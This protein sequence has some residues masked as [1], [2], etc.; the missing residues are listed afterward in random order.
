MRLTGR[1]WGAIGIGVIAG[2]LAYP[3]GR[4]E[5]L[6]VAGAAILLPA[7]GWVVA[8]VRRPRFEV[9]RAFAPPVAAAGAP[10]LVTLR[11]RNAAA[12]ASTAL[13]WNDALPWDE[14]DAAPRAL[15]PIPAGGPAARVHVAGYELH[16]HRRGVYAIGPLVVENRDP[17]GMAASVAA[18]GQQDRLVVVPEIAELPSGGPA[19]ADGEGAA[20]LV[21]RRISGNDDDLTTREYR[22]GDALRRVHW[23]ASARHGELMVRQEEHRSHPDARI[24]VDT[25]LGGYPDAL[26]DTGETWDASSSSDS[27]E[28][29]VRMTAS[30]GMH[31]EANGFQVTVE[32][33][34]GAQIEPLGERWEGGRR[35]EGFLT[36]LAGVRLLERPESDL[37]ASVSETVGPVFAV[38]GDPEDATVEWLVRRRRGAELAIVFAVQARPGVVEHLTDAGWICVPVDPV[39]APDAAWR[40]VASGGY[41]PDAAFRAGQEAAHGSH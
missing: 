12:G 9:V 29:V 20:Q 41:A 33:T 6:V 18:L 37:A 10:V 5:L 19:L 11:I 3:L 24:V 1:G 27:F 8:R 34:A 39:D 40:A 21:Q 32:E 35:A 22:S 28:W 26:A 25:R 2:V 23:R 7:V 13:V 4:R 36:S 16:P 30:L 15:G 17:F 38:V 14:E 31:L